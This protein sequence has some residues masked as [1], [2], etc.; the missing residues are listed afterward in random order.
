MRGVITFTFLFLFILNVA[1]AESTWIEDFKGGVLRDCEVAETLRLEMPLAEEEAALKFLSS[2]MFLT[3]SAVSIP[4]TGVSV[5]LMVGPRAGDQNLHNLHNG[6]D[7]FTSFF[8]EQG[9][10]AAQACAGKIILAMAPNSLS[11]LPAFLRRI[12]LERDKLAPDHLKN[13]ISLSIATSQ[14]GIG[15]VEEERKRILRE[16]VNLAHRNRNYID[17]IFVKI[18]LPHSDLVLERLLNRAFLGKASAIDK[19][20]I[21]SLAESG[22]ILSETLSL[23]LLQSKA[24][25]KEL[26]LGQFFARIKSPLPREVHWFLLTLGLDLPKV[27]AKGEVFL[28]SVRPESF[29]NLTS[30]EIKFLLDA[31]A[32]NNF[33]EPTVRKVL[34][35]LKVSS[36][37]NRTVIKE[38]LDIF[39]QGEFTFPL[40]LIETLSQS[41]VLNREIA[42]LFLKTYKE[43]DVSLE[44]REEILRGLVN[45]NELDGKVVAFVE[46]ELLTVSLSESTL[47][48]PL[49]RLRLKLLTKQ[50]RL[51]G[52]ISLKLIEALDIWSS[53]SSNFA[54]GVTLLGAGGEEVLKE[55]VKAYEAGKLN[56][57]AKRR[58]LLR[59]P[60]LLRPV[61]SAA[62]EFLL[63][64][65]ENVELRHDSTENLIALGPQV[66]PAVRRKLSTVPQG[67][68]DL[69]LS[70]GRV[71]YSVSPNS[72]EVIPLFQGAIDSS[73]CSRQVQLIEALLRLI[74][75]ESGSRYVDLLIKC[76]ESSKRE[77]QLFVEAFNLRH[78]L[79]VKAVRFLPSLQKQ[80]ES[81]AGVITSTLLMT[82]SSLSEEGF[83]FSKLLLGLSKDE[84]VPTP[85]R[86][87]AIG[88]LVKV[89]PSAI[90][91]R[92][93]VQ[94]EIAAKT[95][96]ILD[97]PTYILRVVPKSYTLG[98]AEELGLLKGILN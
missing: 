14:A 48:G 71:I 75:N 15:L 67:D 10:I 21:L 22:V 66:L 52:E 55:V 32:N 85:L 37:S 43:K 39:Q 98:I 19:E 92:E 17:E 70:L 62:I 65:L 18:L 84:R 8:G 53:E 61:K 59:L 76:L 93:Y 83:P 24:R 78:E 33:A 56:T 25:H 58:A 60:L 20:L 6:N 23:Q 42:L 46:S 31:L 64:N 69:A 1:Y 11:I 28:G 94:A 50:P 12:L 86:Y 44:V 16:L 57:P 34:E 82:L 54:D 35:I 13:L 91:V 95:P 30:L 77:D 38:L 41:K 72:K 96:L 63:Q 49:L 73:S 36:L 80:L 29:S 87:E 88:A 47:W 89:D 2:V 45:L 40:R 27:G 97:E 26:E 68:T 90:N 81:D 9:V 79:K 7:N 74:P 3:A 51:P 5:G 4:P